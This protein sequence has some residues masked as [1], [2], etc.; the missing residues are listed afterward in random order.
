MGD[1][2][3]TTNISELVKK[4]SDD[5]TIEIYSIACTVD[6]VDSAERTC[7]VTPNNG[8]A[9][10]FGVRLQSVVDEDSIEPKGFI[11]FPVVGSEIL[12]TFINSQ[13][14]YVGSYSEVDLYI[15]ESKNE[16]LKAILS[17]LIDAIN[18]IQVTTPQGPSTPPLLNKAEFDAIKLRLDKLLKQ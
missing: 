14:G 8:D 3:A 12:V 9:Q 5:P 11:I 2:A 18:N 10:I 6:S 17:D 16:S 7:D 13:T 4:L 1:S 15:I